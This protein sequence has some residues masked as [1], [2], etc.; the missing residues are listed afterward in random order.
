MFGT[1]ATGELVQ[2]RVYRDADNGSDT[3]TGDAQ[4]IGIKIYYGKS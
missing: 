3:H 2:F 1:P 4:L